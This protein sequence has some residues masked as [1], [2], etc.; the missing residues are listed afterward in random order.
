MQINNNIHL[1]HSRNISQS[2]INNSLEKYKGHEHEENID[3]RTAWRKFSDFWRPGV[4]S[5]EVMLALVKLKE[6]ETR[7]TTDPGS[8]K[9]LATAT[10]L[11]HS[12]IHNAK[13]LHDNISEKDQCLFH[14]SVNTHHDNDSGMQVRTASI[15]IAGE[16]LA[17]MTLQ[18]ASQNEQMRNNSL[19]WACKNFSLSELPAD[20]L[21]HIVTNHLFKNPMTNKIEISYLSDASQR[22]NQRLQQSLKWENTAIGYYDSMGMR[23]ITTMLD[24]LARPFNNALQADPQKVREQITHQGER[25]AL[26]V[27]NVLNR[28]AQS[29][30][31]NE[32]DIL[33]LDRE[34]LSRIV[35]AVDAYI[36]LVDHTVTNEIKN[37]IGGFS[38]S[39]G[40]AFDERDKEIAKLNLSPL[41]DFSY[42]MPGIDA[43]AWELTCDILAVDDGIKSAYG[44]DF[45]PQ[46]NSTKF[47][48]ANSMNDTIMIPNEDKINNTEKQI[49]EH[50]A[51]HECVM[52]EFLDKFI[53][54]ESAFQAHQE[55]RNLFNNTLSDTQGKANLGSYSTFM[56]LKS[57]VDPA[58]QDKFTARLTREPAQYHVEHKIIKVDYY[59]DGEKICSDT[60]PNLIFNMQ[61]TNG[62]PLLNLDIA[63]VSIN[64]CERNRAKF[65]QVM[66]DTDGKLFDFSPDSR[67]LSAG[68]VA[69]TAAS[70]YYFTHSETAESLYQMAGTLGLGEDD[71]LWA[72]Q[73]SI[74]NIPATRENVIKYGSQDNIFKENSFFMVNRSAPAG[75][76]NNVLMMPAMKAWDKCVSLFREEDKVLD[77]APGDMRQLFSLIK[78]GAPNDRLLAQFEILKGKI[79]TD[80]YRRDILHSEI[81][82]EG[83]LGFFVN[84]EPLF[85]FD[86]AITA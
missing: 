77:K 36:S 53:P 20:D 21:Q 15:K 59:I 18:T 79:N 17:S 82:Y 60:L 68:S 46:A 51:S 35:T 85:D 42:V 26:A 5:K 32:R 38:S 63:D 83:K 62:K 66:R 55:L 76:L 25:A 11:S 84:G 69:V 65:D 13:V 48:T 24:S 28:L 86:A 54:Q 7:V 9:D 57:L 2:E 30:T 78:A 74:R 1:T 3:V 19:L 22:G 8:T 40:N 75:V 58:L 31:I 47:M 56:N 29:P 64:F 12:F 27:E 49:I 67:G 52:H 43:A 44:A 70:Q 61:E 50:R 34:T 16:E 14:A 71:F 6:L 41:L 10:A 72:M 37:G 4:D 45:Y 39:I 81:S 23:G 80:S 33:S 73:D